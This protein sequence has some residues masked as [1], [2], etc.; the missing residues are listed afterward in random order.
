MRCHFFN[1]FFI[2]KLLDEAGGYSF[3]NVKRW[4]RK[5]PGKDIF[6]LDKIFFPG[7]FSLYYGRALVII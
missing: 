7:K 3:K 5:V 6:A 2:S 1:S 4:S